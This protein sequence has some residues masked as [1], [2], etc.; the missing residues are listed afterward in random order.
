MIIKKKVMDILNKQINAELESAYLYLSMSAYFESSN[1]PGMAVWMK[2]QTNEEVF[3]AMKL[4]GYV[5]E[6]GGKVVLDAIKKPKLTWKTPLDAFE[7]AYAHEQFITKLI[8]GCVDVALKEK[9]NA[10]RVFMDWYV[11]E[12]VEEESKAS[13]IVE[14]LKLIKN[15]PGGLYILD[16]ELGQRNTQPTTGDTNGKN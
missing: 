6:R 3:H 8:D 15:T 14:K 1:Y 10:T 16:K 12:Q 7:N 5:N 13:E 2:T 4:F 9:D 11:N